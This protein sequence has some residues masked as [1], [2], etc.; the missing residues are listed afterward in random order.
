MDPK[1]L[2]TLRCHKRHTLCPLLCVDQ[3]EHTT[4]T[5]SYRLW[6]PTLLLPALLW[7]SLSVSI[8]LHLTQAQCA[9]HPAARVPQVTAPACK[10][11]PSS[12]VRMASQ[13]LQAS[14]P[15]SPSI[16]LRIL[17]AAVL[18]RPSSEKKCTIGRD[19]VKSKS[20]S[21][22]ELP[23]FIPKFEKLT[24]LEDCA[25]FTSRFYNKT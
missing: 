9:K 22:K 13:A 21:P 10:A 4:S 5:R 8:I 14:A 11:K 15:H 17:I 18:H 3:R 24:Y 12:K 20:L 6:T 2:P 23:C 1:F 19:W 16:Y 7:H 25:P